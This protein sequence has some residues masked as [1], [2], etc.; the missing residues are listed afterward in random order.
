MKTFRFSE[1]ELATIRRRTLGL[2]GAV[3]GL[4]ALVWV[5]LLF[6]RSTVDATVTV[7]FGGLV[8]AVTVF[9]LV[10]LWRRTAQVLAGWQGGWL[11]IDEEAPEHPTRAGVVTRITRAETPEVRETAFWF[12]VSSRAARKYISVPVLAPSARFA[13]L[14]AAVLAWTATQA[15]AASPV[16]SGSAP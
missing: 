15:E 9:N 2:A 6:W 7:G 4:G 10:T 5:A 1:D 14:R 13:A 12:L 3:L 16:D 8:L 11:L